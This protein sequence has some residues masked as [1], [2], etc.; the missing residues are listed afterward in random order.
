MRRGHRAAHGVSA[1][2]LAAALVG[3]IGWA[4]ALRQDPAAAPEPQRV[5]PPAGQ[6]AG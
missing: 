1:W 5:A 3:I 2:L 6:E 4:Y